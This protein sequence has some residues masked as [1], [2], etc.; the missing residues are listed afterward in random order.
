MTWIDHAGKWL[1]ILNDAEVKYDI[2]KNLLARQCYQESGFNP[3]ARNP[4]GAIGIMQLLPKYFPGA[5][6][7]PARDID[8]AGAYLRSLY[9]RFSDWQLALAGYDWGPSA[10][11]KWIKAGRH[12]DKL[13]IETHNYVAEITHDVLIG[14]SLCR[15]QSPQAVGPLPFQPLPAQVSAAA[16]PTW[17]LK[18]LA[19]FFT[20]RG[21]TPQ[22]TL[23]SLPS[24]TEQL[25]ISSPTAVVNKEMIMSTPNPILVAAAPTLIT[26]IG[27]L[28]VM[29][30]TILT[31]DPALAAARVLPATE[32][33]AGKLTLLLPSLATAE[34]GAG[35][36]AINAKLNGLVTQLQAL[37]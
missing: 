36:A 29:I 9:K 33:F 15:T 12:L 37:K 17:S 13:P 18:G 10:L 30:N 22:P 8:S 4:S 32:I 34:L 7:D 14:G 2:P 19:S 25:A 31:G 35:Q 20:K 3:D 24:V 28:Q 16:P 23:H 1:A 21:S 11:T 27:D 26:A 6:K 5:G